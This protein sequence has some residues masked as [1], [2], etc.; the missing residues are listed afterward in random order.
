MKERTPDGP[1]GGDVSGRA[2]QWPSL[3]MITALTAFAGYVDSVGYLSLA[4]LFLS[5][6]SGNST[7]LGASLATGNM[8]MVS[9]IAAVIGCFVAGVVVGTLLADS[10]PS[11]KTRVI[12]AVETA[13][14]AVGLGATSGGAGFAGLMPVV[15]AM[16]MQNALHRT[17]VGADVGKTFVT[18]VLVALGQAV[19]RAARARK[20]RPEISLLALSWIAFVGGAT[21]GGL[22]LAATSLLAALS[23]AFAVILVLAIT[24]FCCE[25]S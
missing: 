9:S 18:G 22:M 14:V 11:A 15:T 4:G 8:A 25:R 17:I 20:W 12:L 2:G 21:A 10:I 16:G 6:M 3:S 1:R 19:T 7:S 24:A 5:F 13:L 23:L